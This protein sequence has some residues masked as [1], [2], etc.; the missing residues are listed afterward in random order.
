[1][2]GS[3]SMQADLRQPSRKAMR[4]QARA[5]RRQTAGPLAET[6]KKRKRQTLRPANA[7]AG[8]KGGSANAL[9]RKQ[10]RSDARAPLQHSH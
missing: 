3:V 2:L 5:E 10:R 6:S 4:A 8:K 1:M 9:G 7:A